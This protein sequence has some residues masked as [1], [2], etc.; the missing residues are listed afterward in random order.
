MNEMT[1][2]DWEMLFHLLAKVHCQESHVCPE[3]GALLIRK[4]AE[5]GRL[6]VLGEIVSWF[7]GDVH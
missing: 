5:H 3:R 4:A 7:G 6:T 1:D 2:R